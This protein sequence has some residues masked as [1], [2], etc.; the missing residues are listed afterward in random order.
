MCLEG[1]SE[2]SQQAIQDR[3]LH[4][5]KELFFY[6]S[7]S[8]ELK[9]KLRQCLSEAL[10]RVDQPS[11]AQKHKHPQNMQ[12]QAS[13][14]EPEKHTEE[15]E[16]STH[17][18]TTYTKI[19]AEQTDKKTHSYSQPNLQTHK[20][21]DMPEFNQAHTQSQE[22]SERRDGHSWESLE[23]TPVR[24]CRR[25]LRQICPADLQVSGSATRRRQ[26]VVDTSTESIIEDSIEV[27]R[28]TDR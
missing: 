8:R 19:H 28:T 3:V 23:V 26:T 16:K 11:H 13:S 17:I 12:I 27:T 21:K 6:K 14:H 7:S 4:L 1:G 18:V 20:K 9:K 5:E 25:E 22:G 10:H 15:V 2:D 24:L